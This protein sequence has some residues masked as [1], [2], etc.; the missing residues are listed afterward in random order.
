MTIAPLI[1][2][3]VPAAGLAAARLAQQWGETRPF[4]GLFSGSA[5]TEAPPTDP[6][7]Q[8]LAELNTL[9]QQRL[10]AAGLETSIRFEL[11]SDAQGLHV[12]EPHPHREEIEAVLRQDPAIAQKLAA[13]VPAATSDCDGCG[14]T[15]LADLFAPARPSRVVIDGGEIELRP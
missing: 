1:A 2:V 3:G 12:A 10:Q 4:A 6:V 15:E 7:A 11:Y 13:L 5:S 8:Q 14:P 9:V